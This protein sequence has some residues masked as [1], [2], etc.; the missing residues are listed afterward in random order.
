MKTDSPVFVQQAGVAQGDVAVGIEELFSL[1]VCEFVHAGPPVEAGDP[2]LPLMPL[3]PFPLD[4][5]GEKRKPC[6]ND[7]EVVKGFLSHQKIVGFRLVESRVAVKCNGKCA[8]PDTAMSTD[9]VNHSEDTED[10]C[11]FASKRRLIVWKAGS[12]VVAHY[13]FGECVT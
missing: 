9:D 12:Q 3:D 13:L 5:D 8:V 2:P 6:V 11:R 4:G 1:R 10:P 7:L